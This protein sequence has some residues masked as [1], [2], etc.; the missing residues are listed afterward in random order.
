MNKKL[1]EQFMTTP[2]ITCDIETSIENTIEI[3]KNN[4]IGFLPITKSNILVG[5]ITD[6]DILIRAI[7]KYDLNTS[8]Q[9][10]M[11]SENICFVH[12]STP[13]DEAAEIMA[14][15]KIRRLVVLEDGKVKGV[16]TSKS[17]LTEKSLIHYI[18]KTYQ[19]AYTLPQ[20]E[21]YTNSN[22][23]DSIKAEDFPL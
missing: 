21:I 9:S 23:H 16:L 19:N 13:I 5:V 11:T 17:I 12:P 2:A 22:P 7:G 10:I 8:I 18:V 20:Y 4:N 1:V 3:L 6:R 15:N 14:N